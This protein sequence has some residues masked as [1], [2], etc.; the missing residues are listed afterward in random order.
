LVLAGSFVAAAL[1]VSLALVFVPGA[2]RANKPHTTA[3]TGPSPIAVLPGRVQSVAFSPNG[4]FVAAGTSTGLVRE[5]NVATHVQLNAM[6][7]PNSDGVNDVAVSLDNAVLATA[8]ANGKIYLWSGNRL[9]QTLTDPSGSGVVSVAFSI[10]K[11]FLAIGDADGN[12]YGCPLSGD[13]C[14]GFRSPEVDP[15]SDGVTALAFN[16]GNN[17]LAAGDA[18]GMIFM[19]IKVKTPGSTILDPSGSAIRSVTFTPN[20]KFVVAADAG[21]R[22]YEWGYTSNGNYVKVDEH[23]VVALIDPNSMG[24]ESVRVSSNGQLMAAAD[25]NHHVYL[26]H[27]DTLL[28]SG[29]VDPSSTSVLSVAFDDPGSAESGRASELLAIGDASGSVYLWPVPSDLVRG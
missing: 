23:P 4:A 2:S 27:G 18:N 14:G 16:P 10:D 24:V 13:T 11:K 29:F 8:D 1:A 21:G 22:V 15:H 26:W 12:V 25:A 5:W 17:A 6:A 20:N 28:R 3:I 7:D 19:W 9:T